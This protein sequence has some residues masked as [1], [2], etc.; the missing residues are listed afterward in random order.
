MPKTAFSSPGQT[1]QLFQGKNVVARLKATVLIVFASRQ[2]TLFSTLLK[3]WP[4]S[5]T[6]L[7]LKHVPN[8]MKCFNPLYR[9]NPP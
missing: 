6:S 5:I 8:P 9:G 2:L 4:M 1:N 3:I 7:S